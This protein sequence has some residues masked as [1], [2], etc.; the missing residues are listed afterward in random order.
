MRHSLK[1]VVLVF[2]FILNFTPAK[3]TD[4]LTLP[5]KPV[6]TP[7]TS[8][9]KFEHDGLY[10]SVNDHDRS[11]FNKRNLENA[12]ERAYYPQLIMPKMKLRYLEPTRPTVTETRRRVNQYDW[13]IPQKISYTTRPP[14]GIPNFDAAIWARRNEM[15]RLKTRRPIA[16]KK[17]FRIV[18]V[19]PG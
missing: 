13:R 5:S 2:F 4:T 1:I 12:D 14:F 17:K 9:N 10:K 6:L 16:R 3:F 19:F 15:K 11:S 7:V 8:A 18:P